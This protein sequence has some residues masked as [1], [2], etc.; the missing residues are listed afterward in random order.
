MNTGFS[1]VH[2]DNH[3]KTR[4]FPRGLHGNTVSW[5]IGLLE[6]AGLQQGSG[7]GYDGGFF[8]SMYRKVNGQKFEI[9]K[10]CE[11][12]GLEHSRATPMC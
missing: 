10:D 12:V 2:Q 6:S 9:R 5:G 11:G 1:G 7:L 4:A 3:N 8:T